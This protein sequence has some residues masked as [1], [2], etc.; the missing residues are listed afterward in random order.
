M[1]LID[2]NIMT[3]GVV[4]E[5]HVT[6]VTVN[7]EDGSLVGGNTMPVSIPAGWIHDDTQCTVTGQSSLVCLDIRTGI[8]QVLDLNN[9]K[10]F[11]AALP[12][13]SNS[14]PQPQLLESILVVGL[15]FNK[16]QTI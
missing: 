1:K 11:S 5:S 13:V 6:V 9:P 7:E 8:I 15:L 12:Q 10:M 16:I 4:A 3:V 2:G 14:G